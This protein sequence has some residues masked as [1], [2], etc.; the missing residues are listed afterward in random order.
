[1]VEFGE[2]EARQQRRAVW[3]AVDVDE[4]GIGLSQGAE[5]GAVLVGAGLAEAGDADDDEAGVDGLEHVWA[6]A[7]LFERAG[8]VIL[9]Q[10]VGILDEALDDLDAEGGA[11]VG[12]DGAFA[13]AED[14]VIE[15]DVVFVAAPIADLVAGARALKLDDVCAEI[16]EEHGAHGGCQEVRDVDDLDAGERLLAFGAGRI[17]HVGLLRCRILK[18]RI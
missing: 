1:M 13:A 8:A 12:C 4:T 17:G 10:D 16:S 7:P 2:A 14:F 9:N 18:S 3:F 6:D 11:H 15:A 5:A